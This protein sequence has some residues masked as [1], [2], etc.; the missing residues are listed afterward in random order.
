MPQAAEIPR[1]SH[2]FRRRDSLIPVDAV[3]LLPSRTLH[4]F[5]C[6]LALPKA[7]PLLFLWSE[8][9]V[10]RSSPAKVAATPTP[11][12][13]SPQEQAVTSSLTLPRHADPLGGLPRTGASPEQRV[14]RRPSRRA[15]TTPFSGEA[16]ARYWSPNHSR[17][18]EH[19]RVGL[20]LPVNW[21]VRSVIMFASCYLSPTTK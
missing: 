12:C 18:I 7:L 14:R 16:A 19:L 1:R 9:A 5:P 20:D 2:L 13:S 11:R 4:H 10:V 17:L 3:T 15:T 8:G 21:Y 6:V